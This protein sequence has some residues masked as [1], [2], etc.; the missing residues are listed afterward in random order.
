M[1]KYAAECKLSEEKGIVLDSKGE[2]LAVTRVDRLDF[3]NRIVACV[4]AC[5]GIE[6]PADLRKQRDEL[7]EALRAKGVLA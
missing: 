4:S 1:S 6:D 2:V 3:A 5:E 7:V